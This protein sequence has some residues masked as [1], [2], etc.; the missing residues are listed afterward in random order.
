MLALQRRGRPPA[1]LDGPPSR[2]TIGFFRG[3]RRL[4]ERGPDAP[5]R[6]LVRVTSK[7]RAPPAPDRASS[8]ER[9]ATS[10]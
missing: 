6:A 3:D 2:Y 1:A 7:Q 9:S 4:W 8:D 5:A 10:A